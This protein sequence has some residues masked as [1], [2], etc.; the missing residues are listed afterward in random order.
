MQNTEQ[1]TVNWPIEFQPNRCA[2]HVKNE[3]EI[4][5]SAVNVWSW[6]VHARLW[7][8]YYNN[9]QNV[10]FITD[11]ESSIL[12]ENTRFTWRTFGVNLTSQVREYIEGERIAWDARGL[13]GLYVYHAWIIIPRDENNCY[14]ITEE[15]QHGLVARLSKFFFPRRMYTQHQHWLEQLQH[16]AKQGLPPNNLGC[17]QHIQKCER[18]HLNVDNHA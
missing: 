9:S 17:E 2:V 10:N 15:S 18:V 13:L 8:T 6:L 7:P 12:R 4:A 1:T 11:K 16:M 3:L 5:A 14:V